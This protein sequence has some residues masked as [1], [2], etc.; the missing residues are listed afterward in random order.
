M[1]TNIKTF[2]S[3]IFIHWDCDELYEREVGVHLIVAYMPVE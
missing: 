2:V 1:Y 3:F